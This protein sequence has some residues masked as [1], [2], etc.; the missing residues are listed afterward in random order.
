MTRNERYEQWIK[1]NWH[2]WTHTGSYV[3]GARMNMAD[4]MAARAAYMA[5]VYPQPHVEPDGALGYQHTI[6]CRTGVR[7]GVD[8]LKI[9]AQTPQKPEIEALRVISLYHRAMTEKAA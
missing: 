9:T 4:V 8:W 7:V 6:E 5:A 1:A 3:D 2:R